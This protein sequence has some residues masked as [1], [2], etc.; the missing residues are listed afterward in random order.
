[1]GAKGS[2]EVSPQMVEKQNGETIKEVID[3]GHVS[4]EGEALSY[5]RWN[6]YVIV[7]F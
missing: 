4:F 3:P 6:Q 1:M 5:L 7:S 2:E